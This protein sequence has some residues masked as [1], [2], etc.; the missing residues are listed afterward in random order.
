MSSSVIVIVV[1]LVCVLFWP[2][3]VWVAIRLAI[4][5]TEKP[6]IA[7]LTNAALAA[8]AILAIST[9]FAIL[10]MNAITLLAAGYRLI[11]LEVSTIVLVV[12]ALVLRV[13][14]LNL[15]R[16]MRRWDEESRS[17]RV[18][19]RQGDAGVSAH[20]RRDDPPTG[21]PE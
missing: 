17:F 10:G 19:Q 15:I 14:T 7:T 5:A 6:R 12:A 2:L 4:A 3:D 16:L 8:A 11:P 1:A 18:H 9:A 21:G 13:P 20:R